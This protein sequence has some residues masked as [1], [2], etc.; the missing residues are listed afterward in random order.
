M[1]IRINDRLIVGTYGG[2]FF[3]GGGYQ[4]TS[5]VANVYFQKLL[6]SEHIDFIKSPWMYSMMREIGN[7]AQ[8][9]GPV[10]SLDLYGK[11]WIVEEDSRLN[12]Q[13]MPG[14]QYE[15][16]GVGWTQDYQQSVEQLKRNFSYVLSKDMGISY[17]NLMWNFTDDEQYYGIIGEMYQEMKNALCRTQKSTA[18]IAVFVDGESQM[19]IPYEE[20]TRNSQLYLSVYSE[21]LENLGHIGATYDIYLLDDLKDGLVPE[22][23]INI[24]L[25]TTYITE[26]ERA[27]IE[28]Q[29]KKN[30]NILVWIF[31]DGISDGTTTD[32]ALME[33]LTGMD[34]GIISTDI[35]WVYSAKVSNTS[36]WLTSGMSA[37]EPYGV[38]YYDK[39][40][41]VI[42]VTDSTATTLA[43][44]TTTG[45]LAA[46]Q[47]A[48]A[49]KEMNG[50]TS[51]YS[52]V[53]NLP[54]QMLRNMLTHT[55]C[56]SYCSNSSDVIY[57]SDS[58]VALHSLFAG[59][60]TITLPESCTV[61]DVFSREIVGENISSFAVSLSDKE[62]K[63]YRLLD[64]KEELPAIDTSNTYTFSNMPAEG[65]GLF[66]P[67]GSFGGTWPTWSVD[68][69]YGEIVEEGY[70]DSG[71]LHLVSTPSKNTGVVIDAKMVKGET[72]TL[73]MWVKG[74]ASTNK[75]LSLYNNG[76]PVLIGNPEYCGDV[77][78]TEV[79]D[80]WTYIEKTITARVSG[81]AILAA[82]W[83]IADIYIDGLT[84]K[85]S[86]GVD[87]LH[88]LGSFGS[89][90]WHHDY[91]VETVEVSCT[92]SGYTSYIC[93]NCGDSGTKNYVEATGH[94]YTAVITEATC[95]EQGYTTYT[96]S[97]CGDIYVSEYV[98]ATG[99]NYSDWT[100]KT[101]ATLAAAGEKVKTCSCGD[102]IAEPIEK[103]TGKVESW[104]IS[105]GGDIAVNFKMDI[106]ESIQSTASVKIAVNGEET[107][108]AYSALVDGIA[109]IHLAAAQMTENITVTVVN[110][111]DAGTTVNY[112]VRGY[113]DTLLR[114][115]SQGTYHKLVKEML[116]YGA[117][118]QIY[119]GYNSDK[120]AN[121]GI[122]D[123][124]T[125]D[126]PET[127]EEVVISDSINGLEFYGAS[128][129]YRDKIAVRFYFTGDV[130]DYTFKVGEKEYSAASKDGLHYIE[131]ADILP[132]NIN[133][134]IELKVI[135]G[136][137][138]IVVLYGPMNYIARM[139][140]KSS[141]S[142]ELKNLMKA[143]YNY[144]LAAQNVTA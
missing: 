4:F 19:L 132:Q 134:Q 71:A 35:Q 62:T 90:G 7:S 52:A 64:Q 18:D 77:C 117:M 20:S 38:K 87:V 98:D 22:H 72:Y 107:V 89:Y 40:S 131:I 111:E 130:S 44:H 86:S 54:I 28:S 24:F 1:K 128:L 92:Q 46:N 53:P 23:R 118:A 96:C 73:G 9:M 51:I 143:L 137:E 3:N 106:S 88:G 12:L 2:Y 133:S 6:Q 70:E 49:V 74:E 126:I 56:H 94:S 10:D 103:L 5:A 32:V 15:R 141:S 93:A 100:I 123:V 102:A 78:L 76:D 116:N 85:N 11:L 8:Y 29:L 114:D 65:W 135:K 48:L 84:L 110:G 61:Y 95:T 37:N 142:V 101:P 27:A 21:Q 144:Y 59:E 47:V 119:F 14:E 67:E 83:G 55:G 16:A 136:E 120:L 17:Y 57:A 31:T 124:A 99:H 105:L 140:S 68:A 33:S 82:D 26:E 97:G 34:L 30:G 25:G 125:K 108:Y 104:N 60:R 138:S 13:D 43:Y 75:A 122:T 58:Y 42:A 113:C 66:A 80:E 127:V 45:G 63:L 121:K 129:V 109:T 81:L 79:P 39:A 139:N 36:H 115:E 112:S 69:N 50:W 91:I 41:P